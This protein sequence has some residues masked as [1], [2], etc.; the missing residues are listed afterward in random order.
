MANP[1]PEHP[2][3]WKTLGT[4]TRQLP[5]SLFS[6]GVSIVVVLILHFLPAEHALTFGEII[7]VGA[8][9]FVATTIVL[10]EQFVHTA[11][12]Q[13]GV[14]EQKLATS[15]KHLEDLLAL[16]KEDNTKFE[17]SSKTVAELHTELKELLNLVV[18][19]IKT[20]PRLEA[21]TSTLD[22]QSARRVGGDIS[23][24]FNQHARAWI[25]SAERLKINRE[26]VTAYCWTKLVERQLRSQSESLSQGF[27][28]TSSEG[29]TNLVWECCESLSDVYSEQ[30]LTLFLVT[31][32]MPDEFFNWPQAELSKTRRHFRY[33]AHTWKGA[34]AYFDK[35]SKLKTQIRIKR[36]ILT[37]GGRPLTGDVET[38]LHALHLVN[39]LR[40]VSDLWMYD[41]PLSANQLMALD[42]SAVLARTIDD[43]NPTEY[44]RDFVEAESF[45]FYPIGS[46]DDFK[47]G[48]LQ[49]QARLLDTFIKTLHSEEEDALYYQLG[50]SSEDARISDA[51]FFDRGSIPELAMFGVGSKQKDTRW[52]FGIL[53]HLRPFTERMHINFISDITLNSEIGSCLHHIQTNSDSLAHLLMR[54]PA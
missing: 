5:P 48:Y 1:A 33:V 2:S 16:L 15:N 41:R 22:E 11:K 18:E 17:K 51:L 37:K 25:D 39:D 40:E 35:I 10:A 6:L 26:R 50:S 3:K 49:P 29:Y 36:C 34:E 30:N 13:I 53:G 32:M 38:R 14:A 31:G 9:S 43:N 8:M 20:T 28:V 23:R 12:D 52:L 4:W 19:L 45:K 44:L 42:A 7:L 21:L 46:A 54:Q 24:A 47:K 27:V